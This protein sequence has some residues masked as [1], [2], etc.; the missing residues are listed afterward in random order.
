MK[1]SKTIGPTI[2][3]CALFLGSSNAQ[4]RG[5]AED[6]VTALQGKW[7]GGGIVTTDKKNKKVKLR[8]STN[9]TLDTESRTLTMKGRCA[10]SIGS[11][12]LVGHIQYSKDGE[13]FDSVSL[14]IAGRGGASEVS[15]QDNQLTLS[16]TE[17]L[18]NGEIRKNRNLITEQQDQYSI[19]LLSEQNGEYVSRGVLIFK[20]RKS[21]HKKPSQ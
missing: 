4:A 15:L 10:S 9:N 19:D 3:F 11:R 6:Y 17:E 14:T 2:I 5:V 16:N 1:H 7:K 8:C 13:T 18:K 21:G 12:P 20:P